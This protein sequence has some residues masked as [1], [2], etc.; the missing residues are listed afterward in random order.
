M[1]ILGDNDKTIFAAVAIIDNEE[2]LSRC[3]DAVNKAVASFGGEPFYSDKI[4]HVSFASMAGDRKTYLNAIKHVCLF[5]ENENEGKTF[6]EA[7][8]NKKN[9]EKEDES[10]TEAKDYILLQNDCSSN[11]MLNEVSE[12]LK[13]KDKEFDWV[14]ESL[15]KRTKMKR[16]H[17]RVIIG[18]K[19]RKIDDNVKSGCDGDDPSEDFALETDE[20]SESFLKIGEFV[21]TRK[22]VFVF[23][24]DFRF[25]N[26]ELKHPQMEKEVIRCSSLSVVCGKVKKFN[27]PL[28]TKAELEVKIESSK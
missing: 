7:V 17:E 20:I 9:D 10:C 11:E 25:I 13:I 24:Q 26:H 28:K 16:M 5:I 14:D 18:E 3:V 12:D 23:H 2:G 19:E 6:E 4:H 15:C 22:N 27:I 21:G 8:S 1:L